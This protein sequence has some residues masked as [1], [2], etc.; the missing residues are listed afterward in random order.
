MWIFN[1]AIGANPFAVHST[2]APV[3]KCIAHGM[4]IKCLVKPLSNP[5]ILTALCHHGKHNT[6]I[7]AIPMSLFT[8][9]N[10]KFIVAFAFN[11]QVIQRE[12]QIIRRQKVSI[13]RIPKSQIQHKGWI[14]KNK[15]RITNVQRKIIEFYLFFVFN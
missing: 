14:I 3:F 10:S 1:F 12:A 6:Y 8:N 9:Q 4:A 13:D 7:F 11:E 5:F 2:A 15:H